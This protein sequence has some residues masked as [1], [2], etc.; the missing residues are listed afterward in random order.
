LEIL[1]VGDLKLN[2]V[3]EIKF[4][5]HHIS[6]CSERKSKGRPCDNLGV[7]KGEAGAQFMCGVIGRNLSL[8]GIPVERRSTHEAWDWLSNKLRRFETEGE[9]RRSRS[10]RRALLKSL[11]N[12]IY[13]KNNAGAAAIASLF[14]SSDM[15]VETAREILKEQFEHVPAT[16]D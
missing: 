10:T 6:F 15:L 8:A 4:F 16:D 11:L 2:L 9:N 1:I 5:D 3:E 12:L 7:R 14:G 13:T